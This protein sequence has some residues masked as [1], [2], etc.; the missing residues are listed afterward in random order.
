MKASV[1][2][3]KRN[4]FNPRHG[5]IVG[6]IKWDGDKPSVFPK[7]GYSEQVLLDIADLTGNNTITR[8]NH[9][10]VLRNIIIEPSESFRKEEFEKFIECFNS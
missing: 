1:V 7:R 5:D 8:N 2:R 6:L 4:R 10:V 3:L 9:F